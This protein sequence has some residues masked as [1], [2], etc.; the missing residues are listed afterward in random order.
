MC[1]SDLY[2]KPVG[3]VTTRYPLS[4]LVGTE[5]DREATKVHNAGFADPA[6]NAKILN[7]NV[8]NWLTGHVDIPD[9]EA[10]TPRPN[11]VTSVY[12]RY[13]KCLKAPNYTVFSNTT[14]QSDYN[15]KRPPPAQLAVSLESPHNAIHLAVGGFYQKG[16]FNASPVRGANG[17]MGCNET[18]GFDPIFFFHHCFVDYVFWKWQELHDSTTQIKFDDTY[19]GTKTE[20]GY[21]V[22]DGAP[23]PEMPA[24][25]LLTLETPLYPFLT[26]DGETYFKSK[27]VIDVTKLGYGYGPGSLDTIIGGREPGVPHHFPFGFPSEE[28]PIIQKI[29]GINSAD[30]WGSYVVRLYGYVKGKKVEVGREA[31]LSRL[32]LSDCPNCET[33]LEKEF[34]IPLHKDLIDRNVLEKEEGGN[35][36]TSVG[37]HTYDRERFPEDEPG[38]GKVPVVTP[39]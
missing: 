25:T 7:G 10:H 6:T 12:E 30:Y 19:Q 16:V 27:D 4:G 9:D 2:S 39:L 13:L 32:K 28:V 20:V 17:D 21:P 5:A 36:R 29:S 33:H 37:I 15:S 35:Y 11:D 31:V 24:G 38:R 23:G 26:H 22:P 14:S 3:Y 18:A 1:S 34:F 8:G